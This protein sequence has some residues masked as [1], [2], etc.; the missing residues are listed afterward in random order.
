MDED[1]VSVLRECAEDSRESEGDYYADQFATAPEV[2]EEAANEI[3]SLRG[4]VARLRLTD[5]EREAIATAMEHIRCGSELG[6]SD[7]E[8]AG[9]LKTLLER[10]K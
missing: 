5:A 1:I 4:E 8:T 7:R 10:L 9:T 2:F 6:E 3:V